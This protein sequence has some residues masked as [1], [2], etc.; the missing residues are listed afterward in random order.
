MKDLFIKNFSLSEKEI[1]SIY[2]YG[3]R[4]YQ[5]HSDKSDYDFILVMDADV[6]EQDYWLWQDYQDDSSTVI[7]HYHGVEDETK[8]KSDPARYKKFMCD[9]TI[10]TTLSNAKKI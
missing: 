3:S 8:S 5:T 1:L 9:N 4:V 10:R 6:R 2:P 7:F